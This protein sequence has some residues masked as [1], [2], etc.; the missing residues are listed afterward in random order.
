M[1]IQITSQAVKD[2][3]SDALI[4]GAVRKKVDQQATGV[5]LLKITQQVDSALGDLISEA[6]ISREFLGQLGELL[7]IHPM[8]RLAAKRVVVVGLGPQEKLSSRVIQRATATAARHVQSTGAQ[9]IVLALDWEDTGIEPAQAVQAEV[10]GALLGLYTFRKYQSAHLNGNGKGVK[11]V[12]LL[13]NDSTDTFM[14][15]AVHRGIALA[16]ATNF[17]RDL[18]NEPPNVLTPNELANRA[19]AMAKQF[20]LECE[21]LDRPEMDKLGMG[22]LLAVSK[23]SV[24]PPKFIILRYRGAPQSADKGMAL[25]GKGITFDSGGLSLKTAEGMMNMKTD[26]AGAAA[27][28]STMQ[29]IA[30]LKP[31][32]NVTALVPTTEN[33]P[34]GSSYHPGDILRFMNG[35]TIEIVN[36]DAEGRLAL[37]DALSYAVKEGLS[38]II[39]VATL[40]GGISVALGPIMS[41]LFCNDAKLSDEIIAAGKLAGEKF[42]PMPLDEEYSELI[43]SDIADIRQTGGRHASPV[44]AAKVLEHFVGDAKWAHL[45][46]AGTAYID[47]KRPFQEK[48]ATGFAVRTLAELTLLRAK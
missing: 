3:A 11:Q 5:E 12:Q 36:T 13:V 22:G 30:A 4:V 16:E 37:A 48:G 6:S 41:G 14:N 18:V 26:M 39:D 17:A 20:W 38:P 31:T 2:I 15:A 33:M 10:E 32:I 1:D 19:S 35:K 9:Q 45:D 28:I 7:T 47:G 44:N 24:E 8:G 23:G 21:V 46:I 29:A 27:V 25:V 40:T 42:W 34:S 43:A